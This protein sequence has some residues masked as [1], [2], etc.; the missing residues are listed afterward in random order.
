MIWSIMSVASKLFY[1]AGMAAVIGGA[2]AYLLFLSANLILVRKIVAY[3]VTFAAIG[4]FG[5]VTYF[6]SQV[7]MINDVGLMG[8]FDWSMAGMLM[9]TNLGTGLSLI[10]I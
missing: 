5:S 4:L 8:M 3:V 9:D 10:H 7:G 2:S 1:L 6:M